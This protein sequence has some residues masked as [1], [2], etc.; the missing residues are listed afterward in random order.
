MF[1]S[2]RFFCHFLNARG[3][4]KTLSSNYGGACC[5]NSVRRSRQGVLKNFAKFTGKGPVREPL[6]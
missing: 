4:F 2:S 1:S 5:E 3:V 6:F